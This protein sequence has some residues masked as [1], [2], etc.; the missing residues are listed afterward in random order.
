MTNEQMDKS[1]IRQ[2]TD[3]SDKQQINEGKERQGHTVHWTE[4][5]ENNILKSGKQIY[6]QNKDKLS[7]GATKY[8]QANN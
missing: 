3:K 2:Q 8:N 6:I 1:M 5:I 4:V 7:I